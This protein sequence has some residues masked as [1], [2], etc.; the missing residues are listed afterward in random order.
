MLAVETMTTGEAMLVGVV[1]VGSAILLFEVG[2]RSVAGTL[3]RNWVV[4]IRVESTM[5]SD[6]A[7]ETAHKAGGWLLQMSAIGPL[8]A[9][10]VT[11]FRP[12]GEIAAFTILAGLAWMLGF[13]VA[14][15]LAAR[16]ALKPPR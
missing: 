4:G 12:T 7:W 9:G 14:S 11:F 1:L 3:R 8:V 6:D 13:V 2:R 5:A 15:G 10:L 16:R